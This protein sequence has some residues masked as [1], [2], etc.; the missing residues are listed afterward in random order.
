MK[1]SLMPAMNG[2]TR[3]ENKHKGLLHGIMRQ[4]FS[5]LRD[6]ETVNSR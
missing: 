5:C 3:T 4:P 6:D 1:S 2:A